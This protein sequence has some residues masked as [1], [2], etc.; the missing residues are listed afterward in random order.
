MKAVAITGLWMTRAKK[1][2]P[3]EDDRKKG[4]CQC[5]EDSLRE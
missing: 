2:I 5:S 1:Q 4:K 3:C